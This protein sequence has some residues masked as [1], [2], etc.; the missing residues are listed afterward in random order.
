MNI[1]CKGEA[2]LEARLTPDTIA[3]VNN[4]ANGGMYN[5]DMGLVVQFTSADNLH[6][7]LA[8][9]G[10]PVAPRADPSASVA[11]FRVWLIG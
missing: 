1:E 5:D 10:A 4:M 9:P 2:S 11:A 7:A 8:R 3:V 6:A